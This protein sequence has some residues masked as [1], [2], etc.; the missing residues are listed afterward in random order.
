MLMLLKFKLIV[1]RR[2]GEADRVNQ[3]AN[4]FVWTCSAGIGRA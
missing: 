2:R 1:S 3:L 4:E